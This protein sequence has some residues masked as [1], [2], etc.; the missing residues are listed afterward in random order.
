V[1]LKPSISSKKLSC[2]LDAPCG[3]VRRASLYLA[4]TVSDANALR[5]EFR[6]RR[7]AGL[8][9]ITLGQ[10]RWSEGFFFFG[11]RC[12]WSTAAAEIDPSS[13]HRSWWCK[14]RWRAACGLMRRSLFNK[15]STVATR[16]LNN[17]SGAQIFARRVVVAAG[18]ESTRFLPRQLVQ[19]RSTYVLT[20]RT[21]P[22]L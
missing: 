22:P 9:W 8:K 2:A 13:V 15:S 16:D 3:F 4:R 19:L 6:A 5:R 17:E 11:T 14:M 1:P 18:Y 21:S 10:A 20:I 12:L 7:R